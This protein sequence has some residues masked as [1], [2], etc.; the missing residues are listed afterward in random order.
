MSRRRT[1]VI[2]CAAIILFSFQNCGQSNFESFDQEDLLSSS[3]GTV[4]KDTA[5]LAFEVGLDSIA[6]NSCVPNNRGAAGYFTLKASASGNKGGARLTSNF[7][8]TA[9][10]QLVPI[11]GNAEVIDVQY[12]QLIETT[13]PEVEFQLALRSTTDYRAAYTGTAPAGVWGRMDYLS[14]DSWLTPLVDSARR[15]GNVFTPYSN[16]APSGKNRFDFSFAQDI[17]GDYWAGLLGIQSFRGCVSQG[18]QGYGRFALAAGFSE[19]ADKTLIRGPSSAA[20]TSQ[21]SAYGRGYML[22]F[23]Y[24][25][26]RPEAGMRVVKGIQEYNMQNQTQVLENGQPT[27]WECT[28]IP[29][30]SSMQ[31]GP[32]AAPQTSTN[33]VGGA[34]LCNPMRGDFATSNFTALKL[35]KIRELLPSYQ[36]QLGY[37]VRNGV[38]RLCA[39]PVGFDC[40]PNEPFQNIQINGQ[41]QPHPYYVSYNPGERCLNEDNLGVELTKTGEGA[42]NKVCG[43]YITVCTKR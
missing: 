41:A 37:Q 31:R 16:R 34:P 9:Q 3:G 15:R 10:S 17:G 22:Q 32:A 42:L 26:N 24:P 21:S 43:H 1:A 38:T 35:A 30:M 28:E 20:Q 36:W 40:Y 18:C 25:E 29:I 2:A 11:F 5:P 33:E 23:G 6:Y 12:K 19:P 4:T 7:L 14:H 8:Q 13:N 39:V 27:S